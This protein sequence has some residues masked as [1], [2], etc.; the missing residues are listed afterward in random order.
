MTKFYLTFSTL[1][2]IFEVFRKGVTRFFLSEKQRRWYHSCGS[3]FQ[4]NFKINNNLLHFKS[5]RNA[6]QKRFARK[7]SLKKVFIEVLKNSQENICAKV[8]ILIKF[9]LLVQVFFCEFWEI[10]KNTSDGCFWLRKACENTGFLWPAFSRI[11]T[12][13]YSIPPENVSKP[14]VV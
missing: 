8:S 2:F 9:R 3:I 11:R 1:W 13:S 7:C 12:E 14:K 6:V 5:N 4:M 10:F